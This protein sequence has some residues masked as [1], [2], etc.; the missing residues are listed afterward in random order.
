MTALLKANGGAQGIAAGATLRR[1]VARVLAKQFSDMFEK[2]TAPFQYALSTRAGTDCVGHVV[3]L[4]TD[5][6]PNLTVL[7][8]DGVGAYDN[9]LRSSMIS[10]L[11][12]TRARDILPFVIQAYGQPSE[13]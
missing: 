7:S 1:L 5:S 3:R 10:Q 9:T 6:D 4:L 12:A 8:I 2:A 13:Y 11:A